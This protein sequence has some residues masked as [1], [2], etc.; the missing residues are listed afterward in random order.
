MTRWP[1]WHERDQPYVSMRPSDPGLGASPPSRRGR[2]GLQGQA[3]M[4]SQGPLPADGEV[5]ALRRW[6]I[7]GFSFEPLLA[8]SQAQRRAAADSGKPRNR[9]PANHCSNFGRDLDYAIRQALSRIYR[10]PGTSRRPFW[11]GSPMKAHLKVGSTGSTQSTW[12]VNWG[13]PGRGGVA[14]PV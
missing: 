9:R 3:W 7:G 6:R 11:V 4:D 5:R 1:R 14:G 13:W 12:R 2:A 8:H 10:Q